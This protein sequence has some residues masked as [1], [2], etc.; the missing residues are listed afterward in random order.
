M[1]ISAQIDNMFLLGIVV[2]FNFLVI[3]LLQ[4]YG[5]P[6][7]RE[8]EQHEPECSC[9][10]DYLVRAYVWLA[11]SSWSLVTK[12]PAEASLA[13]ATNPAL[14]V[15]SQSA[16]AVIVG[17][18][19]L[20]FAF[21]ALVKRIDVA[22]W[23]AGVGMLVLSANFVAEGLEAWETHAFLGM[24]LACNVPVLCFLVHQYRLQTRSGESKEPVD[25]AVPDPSS[26]SKKLKGGSGKR[27][28]DSHS[29]PAKQT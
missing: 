5:G 28:C 4:F 13:S 17:C 21:L 25:H 16:R 9:E 29:E 8:V 1:T 24:I 7:F 3:L 10:N 19:M 26:S 22:C 6:I 27:R 23:V 2:V 18:W 20:T 11:S 12:P 15:P 14:F